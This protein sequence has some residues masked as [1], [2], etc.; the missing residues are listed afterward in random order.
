[1]TGAQYPSVNFNVVAASTQR[2]NTQENLSPLLT[3]QVNN[4]NAMLVNGNFFHKYGG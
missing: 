3:V 2:K 4:R 1:M